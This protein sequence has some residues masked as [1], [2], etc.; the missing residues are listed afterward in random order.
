MNGASDCGN[1][2]GDGIDD[3]GIDDDSIDDGSIDDDGVEPE[4]AGST[5]D[6]G[7]RAESDA[8]TQPQW[9]LDP[10]LARLA[11]GSNSS[12]PRAG[13]DAGHLGLDL[14]QML[15]LDLDDPAQRDFGDYE[16]REVIGRGGMGVV[17]RAHQRSLDREVALKLLSAGLWASGEYVATLRR[18][19]QHAALLQ[20]PNIVTVYEIGE[21]HGLIYYAMQLLGGNSLAARLQQDGPLP[22]RAAAQ[23]LSSVAEAL[24]YAH[25]LGV[26]HLDLKPGNVLLEEDGTPRIADFGLARR[27]GVA[28]NVDNERVSG[29]PSY[30]APEQARVGA[31][32]LSR[33]TDIWGLGA[34]LYEMLTGKPPFTAAT[35]GET[36]RLVQEARVRSL[37]R[38]AAVPP[39]LEAICH[40][41]LAKVPG[42]RYPS[43][44]ALLDD[45]GRYLDG[46]AVSVRP[47]NL[48]QRLTR[49][50]RRDPKLALTAALAALTLVVGLVATT[51]QWQRAQANAAISSARLWESRRDA[52]LRLEQD[53]KGWEALPRLLA[54]IT[55]QER[56]GKHELA[57][58]E[59]RRI[60]ML[61]GQGAVLIDQAAITDAKPLAVELS[62]DA[63]TLAIGFN[64]QSV[65]WYDAATLRERGRVSLGGLPTSD[66]QPRVP[67]LLRF[68]D[69]HRL[70]VTLDWLSNVATPN[71]GDSW[72]VD[73]D[74]G[75][76]IQPPAAFAGFAEANYSPDGRFAILHDRSRRS[77]CWQLDPWRACSSLTAP[78]PTGSRWKLGRDGRFALLLSH[79]PIEFELF[80]VQ[81]LGHPLATIHAPG[82]TGIAAW[83]E[84]RDGHW[85]ALGDFEGRLYL[86]DLRTRAIRQLPTPRSRE[87]TWLAFSEDDT[88]LAAVTWD[89][90]AYAF[91]VASGNP[92]VAGQMQQDFAPQRVAVSRRQRLLLVSGGGL[93]YRP[94]SS[95]IALW[96]VPEPGTRASPATRIGL[97]PAGHGNAGRYPIGWSPRSGLLATAGVD[98]Q[99]RLWR[100]PLS[101]LLPARAPNQ[102]AEDLHFD[103]RR[104][105]DVEWNHLRLVSPAGVGI[106]PWLT[107]PQ[108]PGFAELVDGGRTLVVT[109]GPELRVYDAPALRL[110]YPPL[111]LPASPQ[112]L[113]ASAD[114]TRVVTTYGG[115]GTDGFHERLL[116]HDT[117]AG[118]RLPGTAQFPGA[119]RRLAFSADHRRLLVLGATTTAT[120]VYATDT[121]RRLGEYPHDDFQPVQGAAFARDQH[122]V[123]LV[124]LAHENGLGENT[125]V[126][127]DPFADVVREQRVLGVLRPVSVV[128][129]RVGPFVPTLEAELIDPGGPHPRQPRRLTTD[130]TTADLAL[131][132][133]G[134]LL[135]R[136][137][138]H[139][140]QVLDLATGATLGP[141]LAADIPAR[142]SVG[143]LAFSPDG[144]QLLARTLYGRW[145]RWPV[146]A[147]ARPLPQLA[148]ELD[149]L[150]IDA[151]RQR[152]SRATTARERDRLHARDPGPWPQT[153]PRPQPPVARWLFG[154]PVPARA[155]GTSPLLLDMTAAYDFAPETVLNTYFSVLPGLRPRPAGV[156]R[157]AGIDY[158]LRGMAQIGGPNPGGGGDP[159]S[160]AGIGIVVPAIPVAA[161]HVLMTVSTPTP[162]ADVQTVAQVRLHY[163]DGSQAILP[164]RTQR[165][166]PGYTAHD[167]PVPLAWAQ[168]GAP[169]LGPRDLILS[170]PRLPN[171]H[172]ER[173][174]RSLDLELGDNGPVN[175]SV[176][177]A[178]TVEPVIPDRVSRN[179]LLQAAA[180]QGAVARTQPGAKTAPGTR[181][182]P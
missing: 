3:D 14:P 132:P 5:A 143:A 171:P 77:Q 79:S 36:L 62:E 46:R 178:I 166:V 177:L 110:R 67:L 55:E 68:V 43:A 75:R 38:H 103:G 114:G 173:L 179:S 71:E 156:Q 172:P 94:S 168:L 162:I 1:D 32:K 151:D 129:T 51:D 122:D 63:R 136:G 95:T 2:G 52:A 158:D 45:L 35:P 8:G 6:D 72:L 26:L 25:R 70:L 112:R 15:E 86:L 163:R 160:A 9:W 106:T 105:V 53:G 142:D 93:A 120:W 145:L 139:H 181:R 20:H 48:A 148:A 107:L 170:A 11:F 60:G 165:E 115:S 91:D 66:G 141:P 96:R 83:M 29:T 85:L 39:D 109:V 135:A 50:A 102:L 113:L 153:G 27:L 157:L 89:G 37:R 54:N 40:K 101:P 90:Y 69:P 92:L 128:A 123:L 175:S 58:L 17:Y 88:W 22:P 16:L 126:R 155:P 33:A 24:D 12:Q 56:A 111:P 78:T 28:G 161:L 10:A 97:A 182:S 119:L 150:G 47:L 65:R 34:L 7:A 164:I 117:R 81:D 84:S 140:V 98:G 138:Q 87:V 57:L 31:A 169:S 59:R 73:I 108:P 104:V 176:C 49:W 125:L 147:D 118:R 61:L 74:R 149:R 130:D 144:Q 131:S 154:F 23:M 133:D 127:W 4:A 152:V 76:V 18:E 80:A 137:F 64:D 146:A 19:A 100:L 124:T 180:T 174:I 159:G 121:L 82:N 41:C 167:R 99:V 116:V 134:R 44:R 30:M 42:E 21:Q 13:T